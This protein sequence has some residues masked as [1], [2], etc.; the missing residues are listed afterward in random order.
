MRMGESRLS[1]VL[2]IKGRE[3]RLI[4][5][6]RRA[7]S[8]NANITKEAIA[9]RPC[10]LCEHNRPADQAY[11]TLTMASGNRYQ[12]TL[13]PYPILPGHY[14]IIDERHVAQVLDDTRLRDMEEISKRL[15]NYLVFFNGAQAGASAPDHFHFQAVPWDSST[16]A[17]A[18]NSDHLNVK[19][20]SDLLNVHCLNGRFRFIERRAHRP[21]QYYA[22]GE[23]QILISPAAL[24]FAGIIP[25]V[26]LEDYERLSPD[27]LWDILTQ[28]AVNP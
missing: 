8:T 13:N 10:F 3:Y 15:P 4:Y 19:Y 7:K 5:N 6:P 14:T 27:T 23:E 17:A 9:A 25:L 1:R 20:N 21:W 18:A 12:L 26:R 16:L 24:E 28:C 2:T 22:E 11:E